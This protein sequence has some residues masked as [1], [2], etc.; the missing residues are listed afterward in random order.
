MSEG[1]AAV[2]EEAAAGGT[3]GVATEGV[4]AQRQRRAAGGTVVV[5]AAPVGDCQIAAQRAVAHREPRVAAGTTGGAVED[6]AA[7]VR[8]VTTQGAVCN[9]HAP[10]TRK[11]TVVED[12]GAAAAGRIATEGAIG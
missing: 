8:R 1:R 9:L 10:I 5:D 3:G 11:R 7:E 6:A 12:A 4:R 2:V